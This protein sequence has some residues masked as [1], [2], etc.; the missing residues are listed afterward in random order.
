MNHSVGVRRAAVILLGVLSLAAAGPRMV[1]AALYDYTALPD[2][3]DTFTTANF[4]IFVPDQVTALRGIYFY[5]NPYSSDSRYITEDLDF[6]SLVTQA[7]FALLG[8]RLDNMYMDS[9]IGD[10][11]LEALDSFAD[12]SGHSELHH[13]ALYFE[14]YSWG[15]QFSYHFTKWLPGRV[16]G[17]V[18]QKGGYHNTDPAGDAIQ[19]PGYMF[20]GE[21]DLDYRIENLTGIFEEHRLLGARW[22][23]AM[24][25]NAGHERITDRN[26][27]DDYFHVVI[28]KRLPQSWNPDEPVPLRVLTEEGGWLGNRDTHEIGFFPCYDADP[29]LASWCPRRSVAD[30]WQVF[31][32]E[33]AVTDTIPCLP[34]GIEPDQPPLAGR[35]PLLRIAPN[36]TGG[37][38]AIYLEQCP[39]GTY[40]LTVYGLNGEVVRSWSVFHSGA[41]PAQLAWDGRDRRG[42][43]ASAGVYF[44][45]WDLGTKTKTAP[46]RLVR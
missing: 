17:F 7:D 10:A 41:G 44:V 29:G 35:Q 39:A 27:L 19:V 4:R 31:V 36:P 46:L 1:Q 5:V 24:H 22:I 11:V 20:I 38:T 28:D 25:P 8:A 21:L 23:L 3:A 45:C 13:T 16:I 15:G 12:Q 40:P 14:G 30:R 37:P 34:A 18:T 42:L 2:S 26:L 33:G 6:R 43:P 9:G 32:S